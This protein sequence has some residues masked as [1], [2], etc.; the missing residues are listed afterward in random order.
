MCFW[1]LYLDSQLF[2]VYKITSYNRP[3]IQN[4]QENKD[5]VGK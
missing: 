1:N 2:A 5:N 4:V 3:V